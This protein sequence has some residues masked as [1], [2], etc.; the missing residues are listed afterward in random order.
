MQNHPA[1]RDES[2]EEAQHAAQDHGR[3][4][5]VLDVHADEHEALDRQD[6]GSQDRQPRLPIERGGD[7]ESGRAHEL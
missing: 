2:H 7:D 6:R 4:F 5:A 3:D 1:I